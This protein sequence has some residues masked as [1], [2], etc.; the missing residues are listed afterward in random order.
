MTKGQMNRR[1]DSGTFVID[2][3]YIRNQAREA[4]KTFVGPYTGVYEAVTG[5]E[6]RYV[7][8]A[9]SV[10]SLAASTLSQEKKGHR[11]GGPKG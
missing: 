2:G 1:T 5:S 7:Q 8:S 3:A 9:N 10:Q 11:K 4:V 6:R